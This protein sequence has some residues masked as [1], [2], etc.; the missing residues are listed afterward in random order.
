MP[1]D[2]NL[3]RVVAAFLE[4]NLH[5]RIRSAL[6]PPPSALADAS[7]PGAPWGVAFSTQSLVIVG[8]TQSIFSA[9]DSLPRNCPKPGYGFDFLQRALCAR[10]RVPPVIANH[11]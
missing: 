11:F 5:R 10:V 8:E 3:P 1:S 7:G 9:E 6:R 2:R 4:S